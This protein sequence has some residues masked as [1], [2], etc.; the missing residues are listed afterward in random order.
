MSEKFIVK[1]SPA[2][3]GE[4]RIS[5]SKN[6]AGPLLAAAL[7]TDKKCAISNLPK[8]SDVLNLIE[9]IKAMGAEVKWQGKNTVSVCAKNI[10]PEK[11]PAELFEKARMSVLLVGPLLGR[12]SRFKIP[13]PGGDKIG[14]RP[15]TTHLEGLAGFGARVKNT[16]QFYCFERPKIL[17]GAKIVLKEFSV[18]ATENVIMAAA[19][20][21]GKTTIEI[22][23]TEPHVKELGDFLLKMGL[24]IKGQGTHT[25]EIEGSKRLLAGAKWTVPPDYIEAGTFLIA[26]AVTNGQ[27]K[28]KNVRPGDL[29]FFLDKM[30]EIG[31]NFRIQGQNIIVAKS[32]KLKA[33][34]KLQVLPHPGFPTD[35]QPQTCLLLTQTAGKS[36]IHDPLYEN[37][38]SH[39]HELRKMGADIEITDPHRALI[40]GPAKLVG[41]KVDGT[42]IRSTVTLILAGLIAKG[43]TLVSGAEQADRGYEKIEE[44]LRKLGA[45]IKR[46]KE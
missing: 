1:K 25:I 11:I 46:I 6:A 9:V 18:T 17:K 36:L 23:A 39:L 33:V 35:L 7:L 41:T 40:F 8:I 24:K 31:V 5:G 20:A 19:L 45:Q 30:R 34:K 10:N 37:R 29:T 28:I 22:A 2:L 4:V 43:K 14:V 38:F 42:D 27:G 32:P 3:M 16:G 12:F 13:H 44:K 21:K 26:F 15:I